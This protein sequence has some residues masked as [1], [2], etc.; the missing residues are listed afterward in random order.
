M[1]G[2]LLGV[3]I[4]IY[5]EESFSYGIKCF[6]DVLFNG[7]SVKSLLFCFL[8]GAFVFII[9]ASGGVEGLVHDLTVKKQLVTS[10]WSAQLL[11]YL[12]GLLLFIDGVSSIVVAGVASRPL[13]DKL[14]VSR[15]KLAYI[16][17]STASPVAWLFPVNGAG[18]FLMV[19]IGSQ[20]SAGVIDG[21]AFGFILSALPFQLYG[22]F[23]ILLVGL[24]IFSGKELAV[25]KRQV[26][27]RDVQDNDTLI[28]KTDL[29]QG[30]IARSRNM[31][32][33]LLLL[34]ILNFGILF[35]SGEGSLIKGD[36]ASALALSGV[37]TLILTGLFYH[38]Q[39]LADF[40]KYLKWCF[41]GMSDFL[42]IVII[43]ALA[44]TMS[45]VIKSLDTGT[46]IASLCGNVNVA[47]LPLIVFL[48]GILI[49]F[50]TGTSG[51]TVAILIPITLPLAAGLDANISLI[52]GAIISSAVFGDHCS[53][54][55][56]STIL[57]SM[58]AEIPVMEHVR[59]Q[60]P[61]A[62]ISGFLSVI[63]YLMLGFMM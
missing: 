41:H 32:L 21:E 27:F 46:Y 23:S 16:I 53:P 33:P 8:I 34:L 13:F 42:E 63:G 3:A 11:A 31:L 26:S 10:A 4:L 61:Y 62:L 54:I 25:M 49:S 17:D 24:G 39:G 37:L 7:W 14:N 50:A 29:P 40:R 36:G 18:A 15:H 55:S 45:N 20:I 44:F 38:R 59:T 1:G 30:T 35:I 5:K 47:W 12:I 2:I 28:F 22:I 51:G 52:L 56:D 58:I 43:L 19:M 57:S 9:E 6:T 60:M 48:V